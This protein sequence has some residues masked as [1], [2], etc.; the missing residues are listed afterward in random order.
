MALLRMIYRFYGERNSCIS[1]SNFGEMVF[2]KEM[3][4]YIKGVECMLTPRRNAPYN[5]SLISYNGI[6]RINI[7]R[8]G[9]GCGLEEVFFH[10]LVKF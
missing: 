6:V 1:V 4:D 5:C 10:K 3:K 8:R 2:P 7:T 9:N